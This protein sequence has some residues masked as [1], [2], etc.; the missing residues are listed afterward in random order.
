MTALYRV[1][2]LN[3]TAKLSS[4]QRCPFIHPCVPVHG[5]NHDSF[6]RKRSFMELAKTSKLFGDLPDRT[7]SALTV[8]VQLI[9]VQLNPIPTDKFDT[10][11][12]KSSARP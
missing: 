5:F 1:G 11:V 10:S 7:I 4:A 12:I 3:E 9:S 6:K 8:T 2:L